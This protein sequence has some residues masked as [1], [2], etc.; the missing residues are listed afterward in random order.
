MSVVDSFELLLVHI[1]D[2]SIGKVLIFK[3]FSDFF[4]NDIY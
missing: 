3:P 1:L 4:Y 2:K